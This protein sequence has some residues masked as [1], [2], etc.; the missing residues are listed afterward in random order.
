M[1]ISLKR[2]TFVKYCIVKDEWHM[3]QYVRFTPFRTL[4]RKGNAMAS[5]VSTLVRSHIGLINPI[6]KNLGLEQSR[7][8]QDGLARLGRRPLAA[9]VRFKQV[10]FPDFPCA[11]AIPLHG[12]VRC[13]ALYL[14]G[15]A[16]T[17]G[18]LPYAKRFGGEIARATGCATFCVG[19]RLAPEYP[20]PAALD[21]ALTAY[22]HML[23]RFQPDQIA[24]I[25]ESAG[26]GLVYALAQRLKEKNMPPPAHIVA[27][28]PWTDLTMQRDDPERQAKDPLLDRQA[29]LESALLYAGGRPLDDPLLSPLYG[30]LTGLPPSLIIVGTDEILYED[31]VLMDEALKKAGSDST[32]MVAEGMWH[33]YVFYG[34]PES[35]EAIAA[36]CAFLGCPDEACDGTA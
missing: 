17:A 9:S 13:A 20:F 36:I 29:L 27:I 7:K 21:D 22:T 6:I 8:L 12:V 1:I 19:Y 10:N 16:Y 30:D 2:N 18:T 28:S 14:H 5:L 35:H 26:G 24:L 11:W 31:S 33:V 23:T 25:G 4:L 32:L 15:G 3:L 34:V